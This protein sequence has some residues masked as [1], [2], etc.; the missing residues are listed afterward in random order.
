MFDIGGL[1]PGGDRRKSIYHK[2]LG[3]K[4]PAKKLVHGVAFPGDRA[5]IGA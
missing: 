3:A 5:I 2:H 1:G 4:K